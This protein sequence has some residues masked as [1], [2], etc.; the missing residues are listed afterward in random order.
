MGTFSNVQ[1]LRSLADD[2]R[3]R[4]DAQLHFLFQQ[5]PDLMHPVP[6]D[7]S[8][9]ATR[10]TTNASTNAVL[11]SLNLL[12]LTLCEVLAALPDGISLTDTLAALEPLDGFEDVAITDALSNLWRLGLVWGDQTSLHLVRSARENYG[13]YPCGLGPAMASLRR[14]IAEFVADPELLTE[15]LNEASA[16]AKEILFDLAWEQPQRPYKNAARV[17]RP[18]NAKTT[19]QWLLANNLIIAAEENTV[20][21]PR[22]VAMH[23]R[24][25]KLVREL[26]T[27]GPTLV[28]VEYPINRIDSAGI[29]GVLTALSS[30][31]EII[32]ALAEEPI[33]P[34]RSGGLAHRDFVGL[35]Q[36]CSLSVESL[37]LFLEICLAAGLIACDETYGWMPANEYDRWLTKPDETRWQLLANTWVYMDRAPHL[38]NS[39]MGEKV[40]AL[41]TLVS[42]P[43][44]GVL[45]ANVLS[46]LMSLPTGQAVSTEEVVSTLAW[47]A[48]RRFSQAHNESAAAII[49]EAELLGVTGANALTSYGRLVAEGEDASSVIANCLP[50]FVDHIIVQADLTALAPGRLPV[51]Q[52]RT[53][54]LIAEVESAG[55]A[56]TYRFTPASILRAIDHGK[57]AGEIKDFLLSVSRTELPQPLLYLID[58]VARK[59]GHLRMGHATVY[60]RCDDS[61]IL[62][63]LL[64][65]KRL[66][67]LKL[68]QLAEGIIITEQSD[69]I[70]LRKLRDAGYSP[71]AENADG[72]L[73]ITATKTNRG[74][75][76][77][78]INALIPRSNP[79]RYIAAAIKSV[80]AGERATQVNETNQ[81]SSLKTSTKETLEIL[82]QALQM[83]CEIW[84][85]YS[86]KG[87]LTTARIIEPLTISGG[88]LTAFDT[89]TSEVKTFTIS[90]IS[91]AQFL[92]EN[93]EGEAS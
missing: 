33:S 83:S 17:I 36:T 61:N 81:P 56:T 26:P 52:R 22:E 42:R 4:T 1:R 91:G 6:N 67:P 40:T 47:R 89:R 82:N 10:A 12:E 35:A 3:N 64:A 18:E 25:N 74:M 43:N 87:G 55:V 7:V 84:I 20:V 21:M 57:N 8:Q 41:S 72:T 5:R 79:E 9:L 60:L 53:M 75:G 88:F 93:T 45:R 68:R 29:H 66:K 34:L 16:D 62:N 24:G 51:A 2:L 73:A 77:P 86:D 38:I 59:H 14:E 80:R 46:L 11:D 70:V 65:D 76:Q 78:A 28:G 32:A 85:S 39:E 23:L 54:A 30:V 15:L 19:A 31:E 50:P 69:D 58:D 71:T 44:F 63:A 90:R 37:A 13:K 92:D 27:S 49:I 48:P